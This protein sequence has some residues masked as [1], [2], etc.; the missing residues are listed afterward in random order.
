MTN[1]IARFSELMPAIKDYRVVVV[2]GARCVGK[3]HLISRIVEADPARM[4]YECLKPRKQF[5]QPNGR[6]GGLP[7]G[8]EMQQ[9]HIWVL[10]VLRQLQAR[11]IINRSMPSSLY[12]DGPNNERAD[13]WVKLME[14]V[15]GVT[16][17][18]TPTERSHARRIARAGRSAESTSIQVERNGIQRAVAALP[19]NRVIVFLDTDLD[20]P[21]AAN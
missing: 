8:L 5:L 10:D 14:A 4:V 21:T 7:A 1:I 18:V 11:V 9:S 19:Q 6:A 16:V 17:L 20:F 2:E 15:D 12:F 3:D 13:M